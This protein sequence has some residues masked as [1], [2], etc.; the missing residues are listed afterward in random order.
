MRSPG[1]EWTTWF[2]RPRPMKPAPI[3]PTRMGLPAAS[4]ALRAL[5]TMIMASPRDLDAEGHLLAQPLLPGLQEGSVPVL[6]RDHGDRQGPLEPKARVV[7]AQRPL[8]RWAVELADLV[9]RLRPVGQD[10]VAMGEALGDEQRA[11]VV[12]GELD[13]DVLEPGRRLR[14]EVHDDVEDRPASAPHELG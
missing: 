9:A 5:S 6:L 1:T 3:M 11:M 2:S 8:V 4:R 7:V 10:L 12:L 13:L 14:P